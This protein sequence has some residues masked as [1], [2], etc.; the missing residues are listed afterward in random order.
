[1]T[2][3]PSQE[4]T[5][6]ALRLQVPA[7]KKM[8]VQVQCASYFRS[9]RWRHWFDIATCFLAHPLAHSSRIRRAYQSWVIRATVHMQSHA[10]KHCLKLPYIYVPPSTPGLSHEET[11]VDDTMMTRS[12]SLAMIWDFPLAR[13]CYEQIIYGDNKFCICKSKQTRRDVAAVSRFG[14]ILRPIP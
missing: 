1:M 7:K 2:D 6:L 5:S 13:Y 10:I 4:L 14:S 9:R 11:K 12:N 3:I 8:S